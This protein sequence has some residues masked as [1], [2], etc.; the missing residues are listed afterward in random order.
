MK[1][2]IVILL[3]IL[4]LLPLLLT[5][6]K[7]D[8]GGEETPEATTT[9]ATTEYDYS[10]IPDVIE[11]HE[12]KLVTAPE[13]G[14]LAYCTYTEKYYV[15]D[16][17]VENNGDITLTSYSPGTTLI[18]VKNS[19]GEEMSINVTVGLDYNFEKIDINEFEMPEDYV[20][21]NKFGMSPY[22]D[23]NARALQNAIDSLTDGGVVYIPKGNYKCGFVQLKSNIT[24]RL[25]GILPDYNT[26]FT[27]ELADRIDSGK[28]FAQIIAVNA[29]MFANT[30]RSGYGRYGADNLKIT[31]GVLDMDGKARGFIW[32]CAENVLLENVVM[33][34]CPN[35]HAIQVTGSK[36]VVI[37]NVM[38]AGYNAGS[39]VSGSELI[40]VETSHPGAIQGYTATKFDENEFYN[41]ENVTIENCY[42]GKSDKYD[43][44][45]YFIGHH[46]HNA[47]PSVTG[48]TIKGCTFDDPRIVA[49]RAY[50]FADLD[51]SDCKFISEEANSVVS[52]GRYMIELTL[53]TGAVKLPSGAYLATAETRGGCNNVRIHNNEFI[54]GE[55]SQI[56]GFVKTLNTGIVEYDAMGY[57]NILRADFY[58]STPKSFTGYELVT[59]RISELRIYDN[60]FTVQNNANETLFFLKGVRGMELKGNTFDM[61]GELI[62]DDDEYGVYS[63][64]STSMKDY[65]RNFVVGAVAA[66]NSVPIVLETSDDDVMAYC[67][68]SDKS[69]VYTLTVICE[70]GGI[71][72]RRVDKDGVLYV[73]PVADN[74]YEF[75]GYSADG[76]LLDGD[77][78]AFGASTVVEAIFVKK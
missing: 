14:M 53:K 44:A 39:N 66:N 43:A 71:I 57:S 7:K 37:R 28:D 67:T 73:T 78:F 59:A 54:L 41:C 72:E 40:Q 31:G 16:A 75:A 15:A 42:F 55:D 21:A 69:R 46:V 61:W 64:K 70:E 62:V 45:T 29:D 68:A 32:C 8:D 25:E 23:D 27:D 52:E 58:T 49:I 56:I 4:M 48:F 51:I 9:A 6:C 47:A 19:Y 5:S 24:L 38:F 36:N 13:L 50:A 76:E 65:E 74:G 30:E 77:S 34:D 35:D 10:K 22:T 33:K 11:P 3:C 1:K 63:E 18:T 26:E 12:R 20:Y 60:D 2:S 17:K